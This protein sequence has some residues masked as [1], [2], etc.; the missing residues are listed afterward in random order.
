MDITNITIIFYQFFTQSRLGTHTSGTKKDSWYYAS[1][2]KNKTLIVY[3]TY[4]YNEKNMV[5]LIV[6]TR[7]TFRGILIYLSVTLNHPPRDSSTNG[8]YDRWVAPTATDLPIP[9]TF[10]SMIAARKI[11]W[12][13]ANT[14]SISI[15]ESDDNLRL[16]FHYFFFPWFIY[17]FTWCCLF[18]IRDRR[19]NS[20]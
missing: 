10:P 15:Y 12:A 3:V 9:D 6:S 4:I 5:H 7:K 19:E 14:P 18:L 17:V 16:N 1:S 8:N 2:K 20:Q 11:L 13:A